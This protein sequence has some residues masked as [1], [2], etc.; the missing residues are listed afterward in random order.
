[1]RLGTLP[2]P[3][4]PRFTPPRA[5]GLRSSDW[6]R[7]ALLS[8]PLCSQRDS[9]ADRPS[10]GPSRAAGSTAQT[11]DLGQA[12]QGPRSQDPAL[13]GRGLPQALLLPQRR[14][15]PPPGPPAVQLGFIPELLPP[16]GHGL[17]GV[18]STFVAFHLFLF[19]SHLAGGKQVGRRQ[20]TRHA[21]SSFGGPFPLPKDTNHRG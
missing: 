6:K 17:I 7:G 10:G 18:I 1:M 3:V 16:S 2:R 9:Q 5:T 14:A 15:P 19:S 4:R 13:P 12:R 8:P 11:T 20:L 21:S